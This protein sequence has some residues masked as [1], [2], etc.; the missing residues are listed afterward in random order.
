MIKKVIVSTLF[1]FLSLM[2]FSPLIS[3]EAVKPWKEISETKKKELIAYLKANWKSPEDYVI[4][5]FARYDI[6]FIGEFH[7]IKHDVELIQNLIPRLYAAGIYDLGIEFLPYEEQARINR[8]INS[9]KYD[10]DLARS[11]MFQFDP[12]WGYVEY[13]DILKKAWQLNNSL[14]KDQPRFRIVGL[15]YIPDW[16]VLQ[17][18]MTVNLWEK[19]WHKGDPDQHMAEVILKEFVAQKKKALIY[20]GMHH[21]FT[22]YYQPVY[23][24][25]KKV[26][27][28]LHKGRMGNIIAEKIPDKV[29]TIFLHSPWMAK[30]SFT[31]LIYPVGGVIDLV[32]A[33]FE[34][35][36]V[37]FD[38]KGSPFGELEDPETYYSIGYDRFTLSV[39]CDG[40]IFQKHFKDYQVCTVDEQFVTNDNLKEAISRIF[41]FDWRR[42]I[43]KPEDI[44]IAMKNDAEIKRRFRYLK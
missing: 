6:V 13:M 3:Q 37:G 8:L 42:R 27:I 16:S 7:R 43:T 35:K 25:E 34:D 14:S 31:E 12:C 32:M 24:F 18:K 20:S 38:V 23:D 9:E 41:N 17:E 44:I 2:W 15:N 39:F 11:L 5:K 1:S 10:E 33:E 28:R 21:A 26:L 29:F 4:E 30:T 19:F 40:Y 36:R 22:K